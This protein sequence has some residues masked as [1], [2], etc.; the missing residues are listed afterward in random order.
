M[1]GKLA[2]VTV[3]P[4]TVDDV[5]ALA[6]LVH[7]E[8]HVHRHLDLRPPLDWIGFQPYLLAE[9]EREIVAA[10]ACPPDPPGIAWIRL[11]AVAT[12]TPIRQ[13]WGELWSAVLEHFLRSGSSL[14]VAAIPLHSWFHTLLE[15]SEFEQTNKVVV[16]SWRRGASLRLRVSRR[17]AIR[18]MKLADLAD[19]EAVDQAAFNLV[20]QNSR[21]SLEIAFRQAAVATVAEE[22]GE[23]IGYQISTATP[24][25]GHLARLAVNPEH[26]G[27]GVGRELVA[28]LLAKFE[29]RGAQVVTVNTQEDNLVSLSLYEKAGFK[30]TGEIYSVYQYFVDGQDLNSK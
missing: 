19:V 4:A 30:P 28:D 22:A 16:L 10:L 14:S 18:E 25:G 13:T 20:W 6:N 12:D 3:R 7:F 29:M 27:K 8:A 2:Q 5:Q 11:F 21:N 26:Q 23:I 24:M 1:I 15:D 9:N 17:T